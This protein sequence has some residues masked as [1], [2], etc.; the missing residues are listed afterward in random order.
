[1]KRGVLLAL[2]AIGMVGCGGDDED[3]SVADQAL[4][5]QVNGQPWTIGS[6]TTNDFLSDEETIWV[7]AHLEADVMCNSFGGGDGPSLII[8]VPRDL[9]AHTLGLSLNMTFVYDE[10]GETQ[11]L[12]GTS[13]VIVVEEITDTQVTASLRATFDGDN[14]VEGRFTAE[15]CPPR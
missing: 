9:G 11:N 14:T 1:M 12:V 15:L 7:D 4:Q 5:G 13:G 10:D 3:V 2:L 8:S 6:A